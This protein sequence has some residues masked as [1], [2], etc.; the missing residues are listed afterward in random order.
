MCSELFRIPLEVG[1]YPIFGIG[2][3][4]ALWALVGGVWLAYWGKRT[5]WSADTMSFVPGLLL[6]AVAIGLIPRLFPAGLP[7]RGYGCMVLLGA[8][9]GIGLALRRARQVGLDPELFISLSFWLFLGGIAGARVF[10]V[11]E[12]WE[13][14]FQYGDWPDKL[15][16]ILNFTEGGL[17]IYGGLIGATIAFV[18]FA[19]RRRLPFLALADLIAPSLAAGLAI[20]RIGCL[21]NG[22]C[23]G[24]ESTQPW[25]VT[26]PVESVPYMEQVRTGRMHGFRLAE[27]TPPAP[28][29]QVTEVDADSPAES[30][31][32][33]VGSIVERIDGRPVDTLLA[34]GEA[35][36]EALVTNSS[37]RL[38][39]DQ[40][41]RITLQAVN[42]PERSRRVHPTQ[43]YSA[44]QA[45]V[46]AWVLWSFYP[47]RRRDGEVIALMLTIYP[48][49]RFLLEMIRVDESPVFGTGL[50]ISQNIS[51]AIFVGAV[52]LWISLCRQPAGTAGFEAARANSQ[53]V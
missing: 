30:T 12:Y 6:G 51:I 18:V 46:L 40:G 33:T 1:G 29:L 41:E 3:L 7:I 32:L 4:L 2:L 28:G 11:I 10:Y 49:A 53:N 34:A 47:F 36:L 22:C 52:G 8:V 9:V 31:G 37:L 44:V 17:V 13:L 20:G 15:W 42:P 45:G 43:I 50:S 48:I 5:G 16:T 25:A 23:F 24:G 19:S 38:E 27:Q 26:F 21:L 35:L 39:L 14:R